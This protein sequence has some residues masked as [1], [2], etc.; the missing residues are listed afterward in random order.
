MRTIALINLQNTLPIG[1]YYGKTIKYI[2]DF[3]IKYVSWMMDKKLIALYGE[4]EDYY[5]KKTKTVV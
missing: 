5:S 2:I 3:D 1:K 4:A